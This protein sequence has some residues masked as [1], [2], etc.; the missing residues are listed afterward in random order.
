[1]SNIS[2]KFNL[3]FDLDGTLVNTDNIYVEVWKELLKKYNIHVTSEFFNTFIKGKNDTSFL[4][5]LLPN[6]DISEIKNISNQKDTLFIEKLERT[7]MEILIE[8]V[9]EFFENNK[10]RT[11]AIVT[12]C[13]KNVA[14]FILQYTKLINYVNL[15]IASEDCIK[16]KPN[17]EPYLNAINKLNLNKEECIIFEDSYTGYLSAKRANVHKICVIISN[18]SCDDIK[19]LREFKINGYTNL[20]VNKILQTQDQMAMNINDDVSQLYKTLNHLP[21]K[22]ISRNTSTLKTGYICD[23]TSFKLIFNDASEKNVVLKISNLVNELSKTAIKLNMY[24]NESYFYNTLGPLMDIN[25]PKFY[26]S[27]IQDKKDGIILENLYD[28]KGLF[29]VNLNTNISLLLQI[30]NNIFTMHKPILFC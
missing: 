8:G 24:K 7:N 25:I 18:N 10:N 15:I 13:N 17:P 9:V 14:R 23:I 28:Y 19:N 20:N 27:F 11:I 16:H 21:L 22:T 30:V 3:I 1:M 6:L 26:G 5:Y 2:D 4:N 12:S 29:N